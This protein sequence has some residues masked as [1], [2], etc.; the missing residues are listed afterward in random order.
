MKLAVEEEFGKK[1]ALDIRHIKDVRNYKVS[2][3]RANTIL[4]FHPHHSVKSIVRSLISNMDKCSDWDDPK[5]Y[6]IHVFKELEKQSP[7]GLKLCLMQLEA[8]C[9]GR[10]ARIQWTTW[11]RCVRGFPG[12]WR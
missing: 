11:E 1:I 3:E 2:I 10:S 8:L 4:S 9:E 6:N 7:V 12:E 5:Y